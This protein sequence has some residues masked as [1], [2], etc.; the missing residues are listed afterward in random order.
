MRL[1]CGCARKMDRFDKKTEVGAAEGEHA[2]IRE[3]FEKGFQ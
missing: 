3:L 1:W 2:I